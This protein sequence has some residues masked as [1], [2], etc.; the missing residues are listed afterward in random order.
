VPATAASLADLDLTKL[1]ASPW[2]RALVAGGFVEDREARLQTFGYDVFN[3][4]DRMVVA[5]IDVTGQSRQM[6]IVVGRFDI[7]RVAA[8][9]V[10]ATV[11]ATEKRWRDCPLWEPPPAEGRE[12]RALALV[13]RTLVQGTPETVRA[14]ID[15]AWGVVPDARSGPLGALWRGLEADRRRP[16]AGLAVVVT[17]EVRGRARDLLELPP[18]LSRL[19]A[20]LDL[21]EDLEATA[22]AIFDAPAQAQAAARQWQGDLRE[23]AQ[24]RMLRVMGLGPIVDG[25]SLAV[26]GARVHGR[27]HIPESRREALSDR[28]LLLLQTL[29]REKAQGGATP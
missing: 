26:E 18:G 19:G 22:E 5:A 13:G 27:L 16:A 9:F 12:L 14:A 28:V 2:S 6:T 7:E 11:G 10:S 25:A 4:A 23:L 3:D 17:D 21:A 24:N 20:R 29:A 1:R 15:A 8:A